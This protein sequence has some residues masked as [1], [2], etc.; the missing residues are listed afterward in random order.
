MIYLPNNRYSIIIHAVHCIL[1]DKKIR[2][3]LEAFYKNL[4]KVVTLYF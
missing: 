4:I 2:T 1:I 3:I